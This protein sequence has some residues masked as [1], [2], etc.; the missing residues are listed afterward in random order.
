MEQSLIVI[1]K[2]GRIVLQTNTV[3]VSTLDEREK[4]LSA[5]LLCHPVRVFEQGELGSADPA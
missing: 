1:F 3:V 5:P 4:G 2:N